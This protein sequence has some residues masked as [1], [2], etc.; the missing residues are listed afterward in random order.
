MRTLLPLLL[1]A[2]LI[3]APRKFPPGF[4]P[5]AQL[6]LTAP[7]EFAADG[8]LRLVESKKITDQP[9][10]I[11]LTQQAFD[12]ASAAH[13][14][15]GMRTIPGSPPDTRAD[16]LGKAYRLNLDAVSLQAR[17]VAEMLQFDKTKA[18]QMFSAIPPMDLPALTCADALVYQVSSYYRALTSVVNSGVTEK[19][20]A[21]EDQVAFLLQ[22]LAQAHNPAQIA[23]LAEVLKS[24]GLTPKQYEAVVAQFNGVLESISGDNR[25]F[26][27]YSAEASAAMSPEMMPAFRK[28]SEKNLNAEQCKDGSA[29][30]EGYWQTPDA[31]RLLTDAKQLRFDSSGKRMLTDAERTTP[32]WQQSLAD[33]EKEV[34]D[35]DVSAEKSEADY[36]HQKCIVY[37]ALVE[38]I[39]PGEQRDKALDEFIAFIGN[40]DLQ[41]QD[42]V[43]WFMPAHAM[44]ERVRSTNNGEPGKVLMAFEKS[45]NPVLCLYA[46]LERTFPKSGPSFAATGS[47]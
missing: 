39:P 18:R 46:A 21:K 8:L 47:F 6:A 13:F 24:T 26:T 17:A 20:R 10:A 41:G 40:S 42:P 28:Y 35:W 23:P 38:L 37:E 36:Y 12:L 3:A 14:K 4:E 22:Y 19:E 27:A 1:A 2:S 7:P 45:G 29:Q 5:I 32:E 11:D 30:T 44:L 33:F 15:V 34:A 16:S 25:S 31:K 43:S 9:T